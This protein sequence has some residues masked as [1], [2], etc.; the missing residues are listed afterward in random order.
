MSLKTQERRKYEKIWTL[1]EYRINSPGERNIHDVDDTIPKGSKVIDF[2][3][4]T[5]RAAHKLHKDGYTVVMID[6]AD[7]C[8]DKEVKRD[9]GPNFRFVQACL[10]DEL[11]I[12]GD[13]AYCTDVLEHI[14]PEKVTAVLS[15]IFKACKHGYLNISTVEDYFGK[16]TGEPLHLTVMPW[17]WWVDQVNSFVTI[18]KVRINPTSVSIWF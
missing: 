16:V 11:H 10:W 14:P 13:Y 8:L 1:D 5:G 12:K 15:N 17:S 4:G 18:D 6:L 7:N 9:I 2:G 3:A